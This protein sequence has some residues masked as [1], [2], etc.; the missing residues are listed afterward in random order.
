MRRKFTLSD[1]PPVAM[2]TA[3]RA[4]IVSLVPLVS[5]ATPRAPKLAVS[6]SIEIKFSRMPLTIQLHPSQRAPSV[7]S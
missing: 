2:I 4:R 3:L 5:T 7:Q 6:V 1:E